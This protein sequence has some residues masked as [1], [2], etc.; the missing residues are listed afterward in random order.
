MAEEVFLS[1]RKRGRIAV[2]LSGRGSN[3]PKIHDAVRDGRIDAEIGLVLSNRRT[4]P[5]SATARE[6]GL[7][8]L[9]LDPEAHP[10]RRDYDREIAPRDPE[11]RRRPR[12]PRGLHEAPDVRRSAASSGTGS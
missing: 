4:R 9:F 8:T 11:A 7:E 5:A 12:L 1:P 3:F 10:D 6:R 2:L